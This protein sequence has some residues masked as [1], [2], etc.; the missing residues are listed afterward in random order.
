MSEKKLI[1]KLELRLSEYFDITKEFWT[2]EKRWNSNEIKGLHY[3]NY[4]KL[5]SRIE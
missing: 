4:K 2:N 1:E 5:K 3:E